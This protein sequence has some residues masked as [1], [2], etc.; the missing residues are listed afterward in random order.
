MIIEL[1]IKKNPMDLF[2]SGHMAGA[3][4]SILSP[5]LSS[6]YYLYTT[7]RFAS[8]WGLYWLLFTHLIAEPEKMGF[9]LFTPQKN[10]GEDP[11][12]FRLYNINIAK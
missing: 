9:D 2:G 6:I 4:G 10:I 8:P 1:S 12:P 7:D 3:K 5:F 11:N